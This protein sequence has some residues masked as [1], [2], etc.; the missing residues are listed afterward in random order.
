MNLY[1]LIDKKKQKETD[2]L[3]ESRLGSKNIIS[4][5]IK[6]EN[7]KISIATIALTE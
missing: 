4:T 1:P 6:A 5:P 7:I 3:I 2:K